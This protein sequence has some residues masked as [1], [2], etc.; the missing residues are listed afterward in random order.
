MARLGAIWANDLWDV[1]IWD[2]DIWE[3]ASAPVISGATVQSDGNSIV[4]RFSTE[5]VFG[6][7]G[8]GGWTL[9]MSGGASAMTY[10]SGVGTKA[11]TYTLARSIASDETGDIDYTQ[12]GD[13]L[14]DVNQTDLATFIDFPV[15]IGGDA[16][17]LRPSISHKSVNLVHNETDIWHNDPTLDHN[18]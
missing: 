9:N 6:A 16:R 2:A 11:L 7:G 17:H 4:P 10:S 18:E 8:N 13:G 15:V 1:A 3:S 14:E 5:I 12:P